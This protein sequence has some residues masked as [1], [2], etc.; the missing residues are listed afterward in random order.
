MHT[1]L[2]SSTLY[3]NF[4][5][6]YRHITVRPYAA[7]MGAEVTGIDVV[8][9]SDE[10]HAE[11]EDALYRHKMIFFRDQLLSDEEHS[12]FTARFGP[13]GKD[14]FSD[15]PETGVLPMVKEA[16]Q[17]VPMVF[18]GGWHTDSPFMEKPPAITVLRSIETPDFG[19]DTSFA[20]AA[21]AYRA[22]S[23]PFRRFLASLRVHMSA[24]PIFERVKKMQ[25]INKGFGTE[26]SFAQAMEGSFHPLVRTHPVTGEQALYIAGN[27]AIG[28]EGMSEHES[29]TLLT[30]LMDHVT[31]HPF[32]CRLRWEPNM[33]VAWD[34]R[35]CLHLA[36]N[37]YDGSRRAMARSTV[38][39]EVPV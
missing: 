37:D 13:L 19:G 4:T 10:A 33:L 12:I 18:G 21:L 11:V 6:E 24:G 23:E 30:F 28:L 27:Y 32:C 14:P 5:H 1:K 25:S 22:L 38:E 3:D 34:N 16:D 15:Q 17:V 29:E 26:A 7:S 36:M 2:V 31:D 35:L 39:G 8:S 9:M 20:N